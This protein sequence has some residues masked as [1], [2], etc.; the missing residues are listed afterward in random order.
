MLSSRVC[1]KNKDEIMA[2]SPASAD[3]SAAPSAAPSVAPRGDLAGRLIAWY[4]RHRRVLP[5]RAAAGERPDPYRVWLSEIM[6]Q[7][8]TVK[9]VG[10]YFRAFVR[11]WPTVHDLAAAELDQVL[12]AWQGLGYYARARNLHRC[13]RVIC[14]EHGGRLPDGEAALGKLPG[15]GPYT[16][17]AIAAIAFDRP[18]TVVDANVAR[19][20]ARLGGVEAPLPRA[21]PRLEALAAALTP[22]VRPGDYAQALMDLGSTL[23]TPRA[24]KCPICPWAGACVAR[25]MGTAESLPRTARKRE[26][27]T[28]R[29]V[30]F[31]AVRADGQVLLRRRAEAGLLGGMMEIPSTEWRTKAWTAREATGQA[32]LRARWRALPGVVRHGFTHFRLEITVMAGRAAEV[33][34]IDGVWCRID[35]LGER[36]LPTLMKKIVKHALAQGR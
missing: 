24:P 10:P 3:S 29:G 23:C 36:A 26:R 33:D 9:T 15:I 4:E 30:A 31:W 2:A 28:R 8:T 19:V 32:P 12:H 7:Q 13:A 14:R 5:W 25:A 11:R 20:M 27:P 6:L 1:E 16:A 35:R 21:R 17:A 34:G 22:S 18:A